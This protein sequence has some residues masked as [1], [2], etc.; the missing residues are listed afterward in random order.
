MRANGKMRFLTV[1]SRFQMMSAG[2]LS[3][4]LIAWLAVSGVMIVTQAEVTAER[5][6]MTAKAESVARTAA[7]VNSYRGSVEERAA[8]LESRQRLLETL[9]EEHFGKPA[10]TAIPETH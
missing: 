9:A 8:G 3:L 6:A 4:A 7:A 1:S 10:A 5:Q 2:A